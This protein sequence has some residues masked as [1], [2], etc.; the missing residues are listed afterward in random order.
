[1]YH[2]ILKKKKKG[3]EKRRKKIGSKA[4]LTPFFTKR[5]LAAPPNCTH[6]HPNL[7]T[8]LLIVL[9]VDVSKMRFDISL[10]Q[11]LVIRKTMLSFIKG[12]WSG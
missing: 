8:L 6:P 7:R 11:L 3:K 1:M 5:R 12:V 9:V 4:G 10:P 2:S